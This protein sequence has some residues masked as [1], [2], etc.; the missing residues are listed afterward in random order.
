[1]AEASSVGADWTEIVFV[2]WFECF[3]VLVFCPFTVIKFLLQRN[4][5]FPQELWLF[6]VWTGLVEAAGQIFGAFWRQTRFVGIFFFWDGQ[7][8][9]ASRCRNEEWW[10]HHS[11]NAFLFLR[12]CCSCVLTFYDK[13]NKNANGSHFDLL[14]RMTQY[15]QQRAPLCVNRRG[16]WVK[17]LTKHWR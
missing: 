17:K 7:F 3:V 9:V 1:M 5:D 11:H 13:W 14:A 6:L 2:R 15:C 4:S 16:S 12:R 10:C 8:C